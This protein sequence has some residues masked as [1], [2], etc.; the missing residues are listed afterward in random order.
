[1]KK[2]RLKII[3]I[4]VGDH[5]IRYRLEN[6]M[7]DSVYHGVPMSYRFPNTEADEAEFW[8]IR[9]SETPEQALKE[10]APPD[11]AILPPETRLTHIAIETLSDDKR[12]YAFY[13]ERDTM[14]TFLITPKD[15]KFYSFDTLEGTTEMFLYSDIRHISFKEV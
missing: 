7:G 12:L 15:V 2:I 14:P 1:M 10:F 8:L 6:H 5:G 3:P 9:T 4:L 11:Y 13:V